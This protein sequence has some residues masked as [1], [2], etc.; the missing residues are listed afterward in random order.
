MTLTRRFHPKS[1][2]ST[3]PSKKLRPK[4]IPPQKI[5][6]SWWNEWLESKWVILDF[7]K[8]IFEEI[9]AKKIHVLVQARK[10]N[11]IYKATQPPHG[12]LGVFMQE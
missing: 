9:L 7:M 3:M 10:E 8:M 11:F 6:I 4:K 12:P 1:K 5:H 2:I